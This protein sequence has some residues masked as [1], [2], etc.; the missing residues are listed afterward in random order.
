M[1]VLVKHLD[2]KSLNQDLDGNG[3]KKELDDYSYKGERWGC[4]QDN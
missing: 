2:I 1:E 3:K 4:G